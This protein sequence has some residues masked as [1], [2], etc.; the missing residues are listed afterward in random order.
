MKYLFLLEKKLKSLANKLGIL[1]K[2]VIF[3]DRVPQKELLRYTAG[4]DFGIIPYPDIDLNTKYCTPNKMFEFLTANVPMI[5]NDSLVTV[6]N[7]FEEF[8]LGNTISFDSAKEV[9]DGVKEAI[10]TMDKKQIKQN[11]K[12]KS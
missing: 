12:N 7:M 11:L 1:G 3:M 8:H 4:A 10:K 2:K 6:G 9:A 5:A